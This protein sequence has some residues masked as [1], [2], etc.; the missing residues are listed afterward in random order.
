M[1]DSGTLSGNNA[2]E[3]TVGPMQHSYQGLKRRLV[4]K[5]T[6]DA[7]GQLDLEASPDGGTTWFPLATAILGS[8]TDFEVYPGMDHRIVF[9]GG[10]SPSA[11][12]WVF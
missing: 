11:D 2:A 1:I 4:T 5:D 8:V 9:S 12:Y 7:S 10:T 6:G 3:L